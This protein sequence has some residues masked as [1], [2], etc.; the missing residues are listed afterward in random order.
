ML[1]FAWQDDNSLKSPD[2]LGLDATWNAV[3]RMP[4]EL[5]DKTSWTEAVRDLLRKEGKSKASVRIQSV[6]QI[7][8]L[9]DGKSDVVVYAAQTKW[10][11]RCARDPQANGCHSGGEFD[12]ERSYGTVAVAMDGVRPLKTLL[13]YFSD[14][15]IWEL[16]DRLFADVD[17][18]NALEFVFRISY[19]EGWR[20]G[21][22]RMD[23]EHSTEV[24]SMECVL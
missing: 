17:G 6:Q 5:K 12:V 8:L 4:V 19:Y 13:F 9:N 1:E 18:D 20:A 10:R 16:N 24:M 3:P 21:V 23:S 2:L 22:I 15:L 7:D 11:G 14:Q